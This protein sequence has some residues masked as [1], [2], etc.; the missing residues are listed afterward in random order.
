[1]MTVDPFWKIKNM[2]TGFHR[3]ER[4]IANYIL[5]HADM[6]ADK[7]MTEIAEAV[8]VA[9]SSVIRFSKILGYEGYREMRLALAKHA[10]VKDR[11]AV[12]ANIEASDTPQALTEKV[13][14]Q[15]M[16]AL[17]STLSLLSMDAM[18]Q[19]VDMLDQSSELLFIGV[20]SSAP[21]AEDMAYRLHR[22]GFPA[23]A[24]T[25]S[26]MSRIYS[27]MLSSDSVAVGISHT[28]R[29]KETVLSM[30]AAKQAGA[31][32][33]SVTS[34]L[35]SPLTSI[36][37]VN[38]VIVSSETAVLNEAISSRIAQ[39]AVLDSLYVGLAMRHCD[40]VTARV[41]NMNRILED[42]RLEP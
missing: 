11:S 33:I 10:A 19:A 6:I 8:H 16:E 31:K 20:G 25:D 14:Y 7:S 17:Q 36:C 40:E 37:D 21:L 32:T 23:S 42:M 24:V 12:F 18:T 1:M 3:V 27:S 22:V 9:P 4:Q 34:F 30:E 29:S 15:S 41:Q 39:I 38:L 13:F 5:E 26:H 35:N 2:Y 28:G